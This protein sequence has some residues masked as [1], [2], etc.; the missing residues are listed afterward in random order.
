MSVQDFFRRGAAL[1]IQSYTKDGHYKT[2][3]DILFYGVRNAPKVSFSSGH[4]PTEQ[5]EQHEYDEVGNPVE[6]E[7]S[8][9]AHNRFRIVCDPLYQRNRHR[10]PRGCISI[11]SDDATE[12]NNCYDIWDM[13]R[14]SEVTSANGAQF[15]LRLSS[16]K[17]L[18]AVECMTYHDNSVD[19]TLCLRLTRAVTTASTQVKAGKRLRGRDVSASQESYTFD[20]PLTS[21][22]PSNLVLLDLDLVKKRLWKP[23]SRWT[24]LSRSVLDQ[25]LAKVDT[26]AA[27]GQGLV[28]P[29]V[30]YDST[31]REAVPSQP[32]RTLGPPSQS[33]IDP[34]LASGR[35][36]VSKRRRTTSPLRDSWETSLENKLPQLSKTVMDTAS[37]VESIPSSKRPRIGSPSVKPYD[38][39]WEAICGR[40]SSH[41]DSSAATSPVAPSIPKQE[42]N[43]PSP[44]LG[45]TF[46]RAA[47]QYGTYDLAL[48]S[49]SGVTESDDD[50]SG[51]IDSEIPGKE[52]DFGP[53]PI[54]TGPEK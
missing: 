1:A 37:A 47:N 15:G 33:L 42:T 52:I 21:C 45:E 31:S 26:P 32:N 39:D 40:S 10:Y 11:L 2:D 36:S 6:I 5:L 27:K 9:H 4:S 24:P 12:N 41:S 22:G 28:V 48:D 54:M 50:A 35:P 25:Q 7:L 44:M 38:Y 19:A 16:G 51:T 53:F 29:P 8:G 23:R 17:Y 43:R 14:N 3:A 18:I 20:V 13:S 30:T 49:D 34:A 46:R